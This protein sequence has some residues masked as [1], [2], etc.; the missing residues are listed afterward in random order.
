M[1]DPKKTYKTRD[2]SEVKVYSTDN[3][4]AYS[5]HGAYRFGMI[6]IAAQW[7]V[8][9]ICDRRD[10]D[11]DL[12]EDHQTITVWANIVWTGDGNIPSID[13]WRNKAFA[14]EALEGT[15]LKRIAC[16]PVEIKY[17][18]GEGL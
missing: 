4:G 8:E 10:S 18:E 14:D 3:G 12:T 16:V 13:I 9:G 11:K 7:T 15:S 6:W 5:V 2:G 1:I 17:M